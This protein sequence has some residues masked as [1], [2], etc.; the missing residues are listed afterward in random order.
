MGAGHRSAAVAISQPTTAARTAIGI[1]SN[2]AE[3]ASKEAMTVAKKG[4]RMIAVAAALFRDH[5]R[6]E[7]EPGKEDRR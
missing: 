7:L 3:P 6:R 1:A 2:A 5:F 4:M